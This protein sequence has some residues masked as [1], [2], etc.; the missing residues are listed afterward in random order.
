VETAK[1]LWKLFVV[2]VVCWAP[3]EHWHCVDYSSLDTHRTCIG[4]TWPTL[5]LHCW[6]GVDV[7]LTC[8]INITYLLTYLVFKKSESKAKQNMGASIM[9]RFRT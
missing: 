2:A 4:V 7:R 6:S 8:L 1:L 9:P 3:K 5:Y